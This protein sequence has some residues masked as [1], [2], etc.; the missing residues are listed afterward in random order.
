[1]KSYMVY[2]RFEGT[3]PFMIRAESE[4]EARRKA[5]EEVQEYL[6]DNLY[7]FLDSMWA[8][9]CEE[10]EEDETAEADEDASLEDKEEDE[11]ECD[12]DPEDDETLLDVA[13]L[14]EGLERMS[15]LLERL[16]NDRGGDGE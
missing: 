1:M 10:W 13:S 12:F 9:D 14:R 8:A 15:E 7:I 4:E 3:I 11:E 6:E 16:K 5:S 2:L